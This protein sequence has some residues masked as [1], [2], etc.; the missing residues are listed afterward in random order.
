MIL[1]APFQLRMFCDSSL[2]Y[3]KLSYSECSEGMSI[4]L[5]VKNST[6][7]PSYQERSDVGSTELAHGETMVSFGLSGGQTGSSHPELGHGS[8]AGAPQDT[9]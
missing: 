9:A 2:R 8:R 5:Q 7:F 4:P 6:T 3:E 1:L